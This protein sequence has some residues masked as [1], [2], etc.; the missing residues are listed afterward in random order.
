MKDHLRRYDRIPGFGMDLYPQGDPRAKLLIKSA[1]QFA[2]KNGNLKRLMEIVECVGD[3]LG[4]APNL[5]AG[6][7]AT[8]YALSLPPGSG[9]TIFAVS[10]TAGWIAHAIEQRQYGGVIRPRARYIGKL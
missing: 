2:G 9:S 8:S 6:L 3:Q 10:R 4:L 7:A 1:Q 5:D